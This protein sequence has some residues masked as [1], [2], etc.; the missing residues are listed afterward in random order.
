[1][2]EGRLHLLE[3]PLD[4][5][6]DFSGFRPTLLPLQKLSLKRAPC[7]LIKFGEAGGGGKSSVQTGDA[8]VKVRHDFDR[9]EFAEAGEFAVQRNDGFLAKAHVGRHC[10]DGGG[11]NAADPT[12]PVGVRIQ[13]RGLFLEAAVDRHYFSCDA[14]WNDDAAAVLLQAEERLAGGDL[15]SRVGHDNAA[16]GADGVRDEWV[17]ANFQAAGGVGPEP[18]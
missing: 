3:P 2:N 7:G 6:L 17:S 1:M 8:K 10:S 15:V 4:S 9:K 5:C 13:Q 14:A 12:A 18:R 11:G 16:N